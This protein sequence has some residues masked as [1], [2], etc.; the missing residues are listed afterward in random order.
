MNAISQIKLTLFFTRGMSLRA[1]EQIGM[2][3]REVALYQQLQ[4]Q[5]VQVGFVTYGDARDLKYTSQLS[6]IKI[7]CNRWGWPSVIYEKLLPFLHAGWLQHSHIIKTN[8]VNGADVALRA[9][10]LWRKSLIARCGYMWSDQAA[11]GGPERAVEVEQARRLEAKVFSAAHQVVVTTPVLRDYVVEKYHQPAAKIKV[12]PNYVLTDLFS[13]DDASGNRV[14]NLLCSVGR[15]GQLKNPQ[16]LVRACAGLD[17]ELVMVGDGPLRQAVEELA[18][19]LKVRLHLM[20]NLPH[21]EL[22]NVLNQAAIFLLTSQIEGHPKALLEAMSCGLPVIGVDSPGI[23]ELLCH[24]ENGWLCPADENS[25]RAA[26]QELL[27]QPSLRAE[28]GRNARRFVVENFAFERVIEME[29]SVLQD[30][31]TTSV[32]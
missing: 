15:L 14:P 20:G 28:L 22:P 21:R 32:R 12:I 23:R 30:L 4:K 2:L 24:R 13:P 17:V 19:E 3:D 18:A 16:L 31:C 9:A 1:W 29:M 11:R 5:G 26:I 7:L 8:Q 27:A 10:R 25:I 6:G